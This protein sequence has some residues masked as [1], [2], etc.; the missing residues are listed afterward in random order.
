MPAPSEEKV[1]NLSDFAGFLSA[2]EREGF[3]FVVIGGCAIGAYSLLLGQ[4][5]LTTDLDLLTTPDTLSDIVLWSRHSNRIELVKAPQPRALQVAVLKWG[6]LEVN[7]LTR[8]RGLPP[9]AQAF[10]NARTFQLQSPQELQVPIADPFDLLSNKL[11]V[12]RPKDQ[13]HIELLKEF[14]H[15]EVVAGFAADGTA[16]DRL[17]AARRLLRVTGSRTLP[18]TLADRLLVL[19]RET[20]DF[21]YLANHVPLHRQ[22]QFL[23]EGCPP[24][25]SSQLET[26]LA[27]RKWE[28]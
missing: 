7:V 16:R 12:A 26:I 13:P 28:D 5:C 11:S 27:T 25:F 3:E 9:A 17:S 18:E 4:T 22:A 15:E 14:L 8:S 24:A 10:Q 20:A 23:L 1:H 2:L 6:E 19:A 21:N